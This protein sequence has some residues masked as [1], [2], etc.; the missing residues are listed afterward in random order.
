MVAHCIPIGPNSASSNLFATLLAYFIPLNLIS[1]L[2]FSPA[3]PQA[4]N[5]QKIKI[6]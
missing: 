5:Q 1:T 6:T 4:A 2:F 3:P